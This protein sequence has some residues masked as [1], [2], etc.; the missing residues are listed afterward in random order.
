MLRGLITFVCMISG[1]GVHV[2]TIVP[3]NILMCVIYL[4]LL[5]GYAIMGELSRIEYR[6]VIVMLRRLIVCSD[7]IQYEAY[8][9][10][11]SFLV[12]SRSLRR[13][14]LLMSE[15]SYFVHHSPWKLK[16]KLDGMVYKLN[17]VKKRLK[18]EKRKGKRLKA[19][20][21]FLSDVVSRL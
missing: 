10:I 8:L 9:A 21:V 19:K 11:K 15:H 13:T 6:C 4:M 12:P 18:W 16:R 3:S 5:Y 20:I 17:V 1:N 7:R 14:S 2:T